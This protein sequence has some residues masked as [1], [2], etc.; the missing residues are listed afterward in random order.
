KTP[1]SGATRWLNDTPLIQMSGR[2]K[3]NDSFWFTFFH[4][5]GHILLHGKKDIF[6]EN[7]Q[8]GDRD[9]EKE[10]EANFF[11]QKWVFSESEKTNVLSYADK[12]GRLTHADV[13]EF[14]KE[15]NT[16]PAMIIGRLQHDQKIPY[17][18]GREFI[19][20]VELDKNSDC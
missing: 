10:E 6:L 20:P 1:I 3:R 19:K 13:I 7:V 11:S 14:A 2:Y 12:T 8:Y 4:E 16:H 17:S 15:F 9:D 18:L 5:A